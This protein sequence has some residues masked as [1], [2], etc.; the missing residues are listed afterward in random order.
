MN[1]WFTAQKIDLEISL[2]LSQSLCQIW[3]EWDGQM[4]D[5]KNI[6]SPASTEGGATEEMSFITPADQ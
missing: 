3:R 6:M 1:S 4:D 2:S 5:Q